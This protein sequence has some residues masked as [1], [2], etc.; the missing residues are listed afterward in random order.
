M[1]AT[2][3]I[4]EARSPEEFAH[5]RRL[6]EEYQASLGISLDFQGFRDE[7]ETLPGAY[8]PPR[9]ALLLASADGNLAGCIA[10]RP[11][12]AEEAE[13]KRLYLRPAYRG[14][15]LGRR[16]VETLTRRAADIG[17]SGLRLDTLATMQAA[18]RLYEAMGFE[19]TAPY[20]EATLAGMR[21]YRKPLAR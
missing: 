15:G 2:I 13:V 11:L 12:D 17:Y 18:M 14:L 19:E 7:L 3:R 21:F 1:P 9:G 8:A 16:L 4:D 5:A 10:M 6:F 20:H